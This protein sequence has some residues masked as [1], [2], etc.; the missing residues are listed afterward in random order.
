MRPGPVRNLILKD[1][2]MKK[3]E[4]IGV[5]DSDWKMVDAIKKLRERNITVSDARTPFPAHGVMKLLGKESRLPYF[6]VVAG[7]ATVIMVFA[8]LYY[9]AVIDYPIRY[10]GKP[11]FAFPSFVVIIYLLTILL[12]FILTVLAFHMRTGLFP[13]KVSD[14]P[15]TGLTDDRFIIILGGDKEMDEEMK[16]TASSILNE[17]GAI[18]IVDNNFNPER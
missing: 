3:K 14:D 8:F 16:A 17:T 18:E 15:V 9:T 10:G 4:I 12:T 1:A 13:D 6:S 11:Y 2:E 5:F 7:I